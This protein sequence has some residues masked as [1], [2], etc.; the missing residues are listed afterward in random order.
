MM[1][2]SILPRVTTEHRQIQILG[3]EAFRQKKINSNKLMGQQVMSQSTHGKQSREVE[4]DTL[5]DELPLGRFDR[6][7]RE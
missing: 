3:V 5:H 7:N 6:V 2:Q 4:L 1:F